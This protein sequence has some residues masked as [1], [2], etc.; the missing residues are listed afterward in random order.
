M[1]SITK[2]EKFITPGELTKDIF[3][4]YDKPFL[5][6]K[7]FEAMERKGKE[8]T[9][10]IDPEV[11]F[12]MATLGLDRKQVAG[13]WGMKPDKF[14]QLCEEYPQIEEYYLMG[15]TAGILNAAKVLEEMVNEKQMIPVIFRLK[16]GGFIEAEKRLGKEANEEQQAKVSIFLPDNGRNEVIEGDYE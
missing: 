12:R 7:Q 3:K 14:K 4:V 6:N 9:I 11:V 1:K 13:Y 5:G 16:T 15:M 10:Y 2:T 8:R